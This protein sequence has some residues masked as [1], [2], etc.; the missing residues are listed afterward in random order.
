MTTRHITEEVSN[1]WEYFSRAGV[2]V[3]DVV[4][5]GIISSFRFIVLIPHFRPT[6]NDGDPR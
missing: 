2:L 5:S 3:G 4:T 6:T 1:L